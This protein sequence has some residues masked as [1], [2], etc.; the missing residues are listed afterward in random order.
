MTKLGTK[1]Q[2][3]LKEKLKENVQTLPIPSWRFER[4]D[5]KCYKPV[6]GSA[7]RRGTILSF[8]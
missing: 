8:F 1:N 3:R 2:K 5:R 4:K 7:F 6:M